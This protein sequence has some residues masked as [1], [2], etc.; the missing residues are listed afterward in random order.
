MS[1]HIGLIAIALFLFCVVGLSSNSEAQARGA[2]WSVSFGNGFYGGYGRVS[3]MAYPRHNR[4]TY[5]RSN[6]FGGHYGG[7]YDYHAPTV[8]WHGSHFDVTPGHYDYHHTG[9]WGHH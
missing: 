2:R 3:H 5:H 9:R 8:R 6:Y 4:H 7:H 1:K